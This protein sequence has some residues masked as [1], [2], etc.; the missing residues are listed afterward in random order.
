MKGFRSY[1]SFNDLKSIL[2][3]L[4]MNDIL[5]K[6]R[7]QREI[8]SGKKIA[9]FSIARIK[10]AKAKKLLKEMKFEKIRK[11]KEEQRN[12]EL[13][14]HVTSKVASFIKDNYVED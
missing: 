13:H 2:K 7:I 8:D 1:R 9:K 5:N 10:I 6:M 3:R 11:E 14:Q 12:K 4:Q